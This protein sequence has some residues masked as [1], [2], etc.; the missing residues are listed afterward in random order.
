MLEKGTSKC[1]NTPLLQDGKNV[2]FPTDSELQILFTKICGG[3]HDGHPYD[4]EACYLEYVSSCK[5]DSLVQPVSGCSLPMSPKI[6]T[7]QAP[8]LDHVSATLDS[9]SCV[10][11]GGSFKPFIADSVKFLDTNRQVSFDSDNIEVRSI[12]YGLSP[13]HI[14]KEFVQSLNSEIRK[15]QSPDLGSFPFRFYHFEVLYCRTPPGICPR[16]VRSLGDPHGHVIGQPMQDLPARIVFGFWNKRFDIIFNYNYTSMNPHTFEADFQ[17][18]MPTTRLPDIWF[19]IFSQINGF[20]VSLNLTDKLRDLF[21]F[22][23][24]L[25][26]FRNCSG[27][28]TLK[29][30]DL[31]VLLAIV[32]WNYP[33]INSVSLMYIF[34]GGMHLQPWQLQYGFGKWSEEFLPKSLNLYLQSECFA[35]LNATLTSL[36]IWLLHWWCTPGISALVSKKDPTKFLTW[37]SAFQIEILKGATLPTTALASELGSRLANPSKLLLCIVYSPEIFPT[38][39]PEMIAKMIPPWENVTGSNCPTDVIAFDHLFFQVHPTVNGHLTPKHLRLESDPQLVYPA[40]TGKSSPSGT[41]LKIKDVTGCTGDKSRIFLIELMEEVFKNGHDITLSKVYKTYRDNHMASNDPA[42]SLM[43]LQMSILYAW[44][45][46][47]KFLGLYKKSFLVHEKTCFFYPTDLEVLKPL[48]SA[49]LGIAVDDPPCLKTYKMNRF[50]AKDISRFAAAQVLSTSN[51]PAV[52]NKAR[53]K[54]KVLAKKQKVTVSRMRQ[55]A[56]ESFLNEDM[57][58]ELSLLTVQD[59]SEPSQQQQPNHSIELGAEQPDEAVLEPDNLSHQPA[60]LMDLSMPDLGESQ[61]YSPSSPTMDIAEDEEPSLDPLAH[62]SD[63][64]FEIDPTELDDFLRSSPTL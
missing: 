55:L 6:L 34:T 5:S 35:I 4:R 24:A 43:P 12:V 3:K 48:F 46:P 29:S 19:K 22:I 32:G 31:A 42:K 14:V 60:E 16:L 64:E 41:G 23:S 8:L 63:L 57:S 52:S 21:S 2:A 49:Y 47:T 9:Q 13:M 61:P 45:Y 37:F 58:A 44:S 33:T 10:D 59:N 26:T 25:F 40:L 17:L 51:D 15:Y 27:T 56:E 36:M 1:T 28:P 30:I 38:F 11:A 62:S 20:A 54:M 7:D 50:N 18:V 39:S 53:K